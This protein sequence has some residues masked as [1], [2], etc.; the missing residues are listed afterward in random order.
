MR[1]GKEKAGKNEA[2]VLLQDERAI[3]CRWQDGQV[4]EQRIIPH[5]EDATGS[6]LLPF[7][8]MT[9]MEY[10][11]H[12][13]VSLIL[14]SSLDEVNCMTNI[15]LQ[16]NILRMPNSVDLIHESL[17]QQCQ[18]WLR[19]V[20]EQGVV[21]NWVVSTLRLLLLNYCKGAKQAFIVVDDDHLSRHV[22]CQ[23]GCMVYARQCNNVDEGL[24][25]KALAESL[26]YLD[27]PASITISPDCDIVYVGADPGRLDLLKRHS[28]RPVYH[29][30]S[31]TAAQWY[32]E[33]FRR[34]RLRIR[35]K[36]SHRQLNHILNGQLDM[37]ESKRKLRT[38]R[39]RFYL[40][41]CLSA[42]IASITVVFT[43]VHGFSSV[44]YLRSVEAR[45]I[46]LS[47]E[48]SLARQ[49]ATAI[50]QSPVQAAELIERLKQFDHI[51]TLDAAE[52][53]TLIADTVT[54]HP[55]IM[56][57]HLEWLMIDNEE[58][59]QWIDVASLENAPVPNGIGRVLKQS[60][61][62]TEIS[63]TII[64]AQIGIEGSVRAVTLRDRQAV[65]NKFVSSLETSPFVAYVEVVTSPL[66]HAVS[67]DVDGSDL[68]FSL[69]ILH[70]SS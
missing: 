3:W 24:S 2:I 12:K 67:S 7:D 18:L 69:Q 35:N 48:I 5:S 21:F 52:V 17:N 45:K 29:E 26:E 44:N 58:A 68:R 9:V 64:G 47:S 34:Q 59:L 33:L 63:R 61:D 54:R 32:F 57:D 30:A 14:D 51:E 6:D 42:G 55:K 41:T 1:A 43:T 4:V 28:A 15:Q 23:Q 38:R 50:H 62:G 65:F 8:R 37:S 27:G 10:F 20:Q 31:I 56:L 60:L 22:L 19:K 46:S 39:K 13:T 25:Q 36:V 66:E 70:W 53:L 40:A 49:S 11:E 16:R